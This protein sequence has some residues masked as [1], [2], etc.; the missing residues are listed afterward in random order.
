MTLNL[1]FFTI[2]IKANQTSL[3]GAI[4]QE[5]IKK[6]HEENYRKSLDFRQML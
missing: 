3:E 5:N 2:T 6:I 1:L 4:H